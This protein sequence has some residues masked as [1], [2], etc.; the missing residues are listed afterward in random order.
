MNNSLLRVLLEY[1]EEERKY[2]YCIPRIK[3]SPA[4]LDNLQKL[5]D[6]RRFCIDRNAID[7]SDFLSGRFR[8]YLEWSEEHTALPQSDHHHKRS[9]FSHYARMKPRDE[10]V[11]YCIS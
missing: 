8:T 3:L 1:P 2:Y 6:G 9:M 10:S 4:D 5:N 11:D 7:E